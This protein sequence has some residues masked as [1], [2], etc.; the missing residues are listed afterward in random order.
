SACV[1]PANTAAEQLLPIDIA[2]LELRDRGVSAIGASHGRA[3][4]EPTLGEIESVARFATHPVVRGPSEPGQIDAALQHEVFDETADRIVDQRGNDRRAHPEAAP[5]PARDVVFAAALPHM[6][7]TGGC[8]AAL[9]GIQAEHHLAETY[10]IVLGC[11][12]DL[13]QLVFT[14]E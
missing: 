1:K 6:K 11:F 10:E 4:A 2:R 3:Y 9:A 14:T 7:R 5:Q 8:D 12:L 13:H